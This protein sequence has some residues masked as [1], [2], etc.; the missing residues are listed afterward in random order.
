MT[1][2]ESKEVIL[3]S[4]MLL[5]L[6]ELPIKKTCSIKNLERL[7]LKGKIKIMSKKPKRVECLV[8]KA[9]LRIILDL[10]PTSEILNIYYIFIK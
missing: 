8:L 10:N 6:N 3:S 4:S 2:L 5:L 9:K 7:S 1:T